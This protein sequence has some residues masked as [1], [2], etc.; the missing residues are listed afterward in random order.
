MKTENNP[1]HE[2]K[3]LQLTIDNKK[4]DWNLQYITG[5]EVKKLANIPE[6]DD[7]FLAIKK[8][9]KDEPI[10]NDTKVDLARPGIEKFFSVKH[11]DL[12][13]TII[14]N[15]KEKSWDKREIS[16]EEVVKLAF[17]N[18]VDNGSTLYTVTYKRGP[19]QNPDGTMV[20]GDKVFVKSKMIFNATPTDK[21]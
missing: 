16:F 9:W 12:P 18:F 5:E 11:I 7:L 21:S 17:D 13:V 1:G 19:E 2:N 20:R 8:P 14:V 4:Y 6:E 3:T 15:G 10:S